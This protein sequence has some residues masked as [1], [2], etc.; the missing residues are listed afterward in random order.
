MK[1]FLSDCF[2]LLRR[3]LRNDIT[4]PHERSV[5]DSHGNTL[6]H[7]VAMVTMDLAE[8]IDVIDLLLSRSLDPR[9]QNNDGKFAAD[10]VRKNDPSYRRLRPAGDLCFYTCGSYSDYL[11]LILGVF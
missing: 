4:R 3:L 2:D 5:G 9:A 7:V 6:L 11:G 8:R 10:Y 1:Y